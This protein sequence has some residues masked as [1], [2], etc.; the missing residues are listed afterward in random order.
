VAKLSVR[1]KNCIASTPSLTTCSRSAT[2]ALLESFPG[3]QD[4]TRIVLD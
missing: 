2:V 1:R 4:I 3:H